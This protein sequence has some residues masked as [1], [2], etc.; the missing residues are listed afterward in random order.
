MTNDVEQTDS[1]LAK[2][3]IGGGFRISPIWI[4]PAVALAVGAWLIFHTIGQQG[5]TITIAFESADGLEEGKTKIKFRQVEI[6]LVKT[7]R[8]KEDLSGIV[9]TAEIKKEAEA[10]L[11]E[12][13]RFW[14]I[15]P[16]LDVTGISGLSTLVS[17]A[18]IE[19]DPGAGSAA[20]Y[21][22]VGIE[23]P[24]VVA[25][26]SPGREYILRTTRLGSYSRSSPVYFR[27][28]NVGEVLGYKMSDDGREI[29]VHVF[30]HAPHF[31]HVRE[32]SRFWN[33][34]GFEVVMDADGMKVKTESLQSLIQGGIAFDTQAEL[35][36]KD[37]SPEKTNFILY[38]NEKEI[39]EA[40]FVL[41]F[42]WVLYFDASVR[43]LNIG[44]PVELR[45][46]KV[47]EVK[48]IRLEVN[49][50]TK[51]SR[52]AVLVMLE[53]QR[54]SLLNL[55]QGQKI[56]DQ[57][58]RNMIGAFIK[59]GLRAR[60]TTASLLTGALI[61]DLGMHPETK[62][63]FKGDSNSIPEIP[64]IPSDL[65]AIKG[66][67]TAVLNKIAALPLEELTES[68]TRT[69]K[70]AERLIGSKEIPHAIKSLDQALTTINRVVA[71]IDTTLSPQAEAALSEAN[72]TLRTV[73]EAIDTGSPLRYDVETMLEE[74]KSA[75]RSVRLFAEYLES[76]PNALIYGKSGRTG[77]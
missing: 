11:T 58:H 5:P 35:L 47:G 1:T 10:F 66:S 71:N 46:I 43:G 77:Q 44:A 45:G 54:V 33:V 73:R 55:K 19:I 21:E 32:N 28:L 75:A 72:L 22:F 40:R 69:V 16:R 61:V 36:G 9:V 68:L 39:E 42:P 20:K 15:R 48:D 27:G 70:S 56:T 18:Y 51:T 64:T 7:V 37:P 49:L 24:P 2:P 59:Q 12:T 38:D 41:S 63:E 31:N 52:I 74:L 25:S 50:E 60:L 14:V 57:I 23:I 8:I 13:T 6:G 3:K 65:D 62:A 29:F 17:G 76:N 34:S 4:F 67:V 26:N 30:I 53:P